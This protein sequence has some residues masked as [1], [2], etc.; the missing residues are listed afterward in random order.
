LLSDIWGISKN[1]QLIADQFAAHGYT[2]LIPDLFNADKFIPSPNFTGEEIAKWIQNGT[3]GNNPHT[4]DT[5]DPIV[6]ASLK[7]LRDRYGAT[8]VGAIGYCF[9]AKYV[10][11]FMHGE[12]GVDVGYIAHPSLV[13]REELTAISGPLSIAAAQTDPI[14]PVEKRRETE[15]ILQDK[16]EPWQMSL[17]SHVGHGF[18]VR[19]NM[20]SKVCRFA[21]EA[22][23][24][25][26]V[27]WFDTWLRI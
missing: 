17:F 4:T 21:K 9:G 7:T 23:F 15:E 1:V 12:N 22:A 27:S 11:R 14:F 16:D 3:H 5:I 19:G 25:Q 20:S 6:I 10:V 24:Y 18:A 13:D 2:T 8:R 26:A